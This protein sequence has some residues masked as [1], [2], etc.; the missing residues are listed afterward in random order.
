M[1]PGTMRAVVDDELRMASHETG[2]L[3]VGFRGR[4]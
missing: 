2:E 1:R 4:E 3:L